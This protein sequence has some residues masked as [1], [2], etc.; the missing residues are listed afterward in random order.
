MIL[1][2]SEFENLQQELRR[3]S[4]GREARGGVKTS[5]LAVLEVEGLNHRVSASGRLRA[6]GAVS[7]TGIMAGRWSVLRDPNDAA[8]LL[9]AATLAEDW[10]EEVRSLPPVGRASLLREADRRRDGEGVGAAFACYRALADSLRV[11][12]DPDRDRIE[13]TLDQLRGPDPALETLA[14]RVLDG[15]PSGT[16]EMRAALVVGLAALNSGYDPGAEAQFRRVLAASC[17][18]GSRH[19]LSA[20][21]NLALMSLIA[22]REF[23]ALMLSRHA[24]RLA[25][26][27]DDDRAMVFALCHRAGSLYQLEDWSRFDQVMR[28]AWTAMERFP[29]GEAPNLVGSLHSY[30][31][32]A[33][34]CRGDAEAAQREFDALVKVAPNDDPVWLASFQAEVLLLRGL[35][36]SARDRL[37]EVQ[38]DRP[39]RTRNGVRACL[40]EVRVLIAEHRN[41]EARDAATVLVDVLSSDAAGWLGPA[42][43]LRA[44]REAGRILEEDLG[45]LELARRSYDAAGLAA[46]DR[47]REIERFTRQFPNQGETRAENREILAEYRLRFEVQHREVLSAVARIFERMHERGEDPFPFLATTGDLGRTCAW[48]ASVLTEDGTWVPILQFISPNVTLRLTHGI[49]PDCRS[50]LR[51]KA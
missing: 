8:R 7:L 29:E 36:R 47:I 2:R 27:V 3:W 30:G 38:I 4:Q 33:A 44:A 35:A 39:P 20:A 25:E 11:D 19:E 28:E 50:N 1:S 18:T 43:R 14:R 37:H 51:P 49:C 12:E 23:E 13:W 24:T 26:L 21:L 48:C 41:D 17:G 9:D 40:A 31:A 45:E 5:R 34:L 6:D 42:D 22:G 46:L 16:L 10:A 15:E 32:V